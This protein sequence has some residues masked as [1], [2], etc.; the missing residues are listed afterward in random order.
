[1]NPEKA[2][3]VLILLA[4]AVGCMKAPENTDV[5]QSD[6]S[7][8]YSI[9]LYDGRYVDCAATFYKKSAPSLPVPL[10]PDAVVTCNGIAMPSNGPGYYV[11]IVNRPGTSYQIR[12]LRPSH[13]ATMV[14][15]VTSF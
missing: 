9:T 11:G 6:L 15:P 13:N 14:S 10:E 1:M 3:A 2:L 8:S 4:G 5:Q 7:V 12:V